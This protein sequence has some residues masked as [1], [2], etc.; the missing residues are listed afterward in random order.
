MVDMRAAYRERYGSPSVV[1][2]RELPNPVPREGEVLVKVR[3]ASV[4]RADMDALYARWGFL[5]LFLGLR[6]P[7]NRRVRHVELRRRSRNPTR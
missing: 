7:R 1:G 3:A 2:L 4:N 5:R 6:R